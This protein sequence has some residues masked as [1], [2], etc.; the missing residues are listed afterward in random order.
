MITN[1][2]IITEIHKKHIVVLVEH[3]VFNVEIPFWKI[4][5][6]FFKVDQTV[7]IEY[8]PDDQ[9]ANHIPV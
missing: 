4:A 3:G 7:R 9:F 8:N 1:N 6:G 5:D 2:G